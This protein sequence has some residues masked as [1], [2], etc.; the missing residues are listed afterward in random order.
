M[1]YRPLGEWLSQLRREGL[2]AQPISMSEGTPFANVL[3]LAKA[4]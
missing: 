1:H 2:D 3:L 4:P